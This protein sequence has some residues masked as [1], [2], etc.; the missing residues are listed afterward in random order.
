MRSC[1]LNF[2]KHDT[3]TVQ[4]DDILLDLEKYIHFKLHAELDSFKNGRGTSLTVNILIIQDV[5][6]HATPQRIIDISTTFSKTQLLKH[7]GID[8]ILYKDIE[9][10]LAR[11]GHRIG[12]GQML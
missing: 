3:N 10:L 2:T 9:A 6:Q 4:Y 12:L 11:L 1:R 8:N 7:D 5:E